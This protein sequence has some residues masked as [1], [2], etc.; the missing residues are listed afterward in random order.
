MKEGENPL[1]A[2]VIQSLLGYRAESDQLDFK[3]ELDT[4]DEF[5]F[6]K[7]VRHIAAMANSEGGHIVIGVVCKK[8]HPFSVPGINESTFIEDVTELGQRTN[9]Y[10][11]CP[12]S[13]SMRQVSVLWNGST[14]NVWA[15]CVKQGRNPVVFTKTGQTARK[16]LFYKND[17]YVRQNAASLPAAS[18]QVEALLRSRG[19]DQVREELKN[20]LGY[21]PQARPAPRTGKRSVIHNLPEPTYTTFVG[22]EE[23]IGALSD[24]FN[25]PNRRVVTV[26]GIGGVGKTALSREFAA[27]LVAGSI[28]VNEPPELILW[29]SAKSREL[30][31]S[32]P[33]ELLPDAVDD[34]YWQVCRIVSE[35]SLEKID[36]PRREA[37][38]ILSTSPCLLVLDNLEGLEDHV[39]ETLTTA[40]VRDVP[41]YTTKMIFTTR[42]VAIREGGNLRLDRL[43]MKDATD[44]VEHELVSR[45]LRLTEDEKERLISKTGRIPLAIK[46]LIG[47]FQRVHDIPQTIQHADQ[48]EALLE[49]IFRETFGVLNTDERLV[50]FASSLEDSATLRTLQAATGLS[51][52]SLERA[53]VRLKEVSFVDYDGRGGVFTLSPLTRGFARSEL[54]KDLELNQHLQQRLKRHK[55]ILR[56]VK[57]EEAFT[58]DMQDALLLC[59]HAEGLMLRGDSRQ[60]EE[61][62]DR[63]E[64]EFVDARRYVLMARGDAEFEAGRFGE[65]LNAYLRA[66]GSAASIPARVS[67]RIGWLLMNKEKQDAERAHGYCRRAVEA[68]AENPL[69]NKL[70][71]EVGITLELEEAE[72]ILLRSLYSEP[73]GPVQRNHNVGVLLVLSELALSEKRTRDGERYLETAEGLDPGNRRAAQLRG[74]VRDPEIMRAIASD[75]KRKGKG[76]RR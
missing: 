26:D 39:I 41:A 64:H 65:A 46:Y 71:G 36:N 11:S 72:E 50:L 70:L 53:L 76:R 35:A 73:R 7:L 20:L 13:F 55:D 33:R 69:Y 8:E 40:V 2:E 56:L 34:V 48:D 42:H 38:A 15:L 62:F 6:L 14:A 18:Y 31:P 52:P 37:L 51:G 1:S 49:F 67:Y 29:L 43:S 12:V 74:A 47:R 63:A 60:A 44:L 57:S 17:I 22:R 16:V 75:V 61:E 58:A 54:S 5:Q 28:E 59:K 19:V 24:F 10:Y 25:N 4:R 30:T 23:A 32:G 66:E 68:E 3:Q 45:G 21:D 27:R 9:S